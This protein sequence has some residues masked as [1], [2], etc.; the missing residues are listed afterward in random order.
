M[1]AS[2]EFTHLGMLQRAE[3]LNIGPLRAAFHAGH[4]QLT[5]LGSF[6]K[7]AEG[8]VEILNR[9]VAGRPAVD[10][11]GAGSGLEHGSHGNAGADY[12][13]PQVGVVAASVAQIMPVQVGAGI[14]LDE[15]SFPAL[16]DL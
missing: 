11:R 9:V 10:I 16:A 8:L 12:R 7:P 15:A 2:V 5:G 13:T 1:D 14:L 6:R 3:V 4:Q